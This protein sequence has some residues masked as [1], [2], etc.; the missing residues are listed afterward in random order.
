MQ[1]RL[2]PPCPLV[3]V[4]ESLRL[5][6]SVLALL[7]VCARLPTDKQKHPSEAATLSRLPL[8][9]LRR[10]RKRPLPIRQHRGLRLRQVRLGAERQGRG[11][12]RHLIG[13]HVEKL[14]EQ[15]PSC[16]R[17]SGRAVPYIVL[18]RGLSP[19]PQ[20]ARHTRGAPHMEGYLCDEHHVFFA[21]QQLGELDENLGAPSCALAP[22]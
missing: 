21:A 12:P 9:P 3:A 5:E 16:E 13:R 7:H 11:G 8:P 6:L 20:P 1:D 10:R 18:S 14:F 4:S 22:R 19:A 15:Q 17:V 2:R